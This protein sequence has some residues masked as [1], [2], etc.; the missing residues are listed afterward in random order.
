M[1]QR[2]ILVAQPGDE[3]VHLRVGGVQGPA[4]ALEVAQLLLLALPRQLRALP[5]PRQPRRSLLG[6]FVF[7]ALLVL[8]SPERST[9]RGV[10]ERARAGSRG[11]LHPGRDE[12]LV[13]IER[14]DVVQDPAPARDVKVVEDVDVIVEHAGVERRERERE[15]VDAHR[16]RDVGPRR[17]IV[18][19][20]SVL[21]GA[22]DGRGPRGVRF[23]GEPA[24]AAVRDG[25]LAA[26]RP[27]PLLLRRNRRGVARVFVQERP[28]P[29]LRRL[30]AAGWHIPF[31]GG[32]GNLRR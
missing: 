29:V 28:D 25:G 11:L 30:L 24:V 3:L 32:V 1:A 16:G 18:R 12:Q 14:E 22:G 2:V 21:G 26:L 17:G 6:I 10:L 13:G 8:G 9:R 20:G 4:S 19:G 5:V 27:S 7:K 31:E 15:F 23:T